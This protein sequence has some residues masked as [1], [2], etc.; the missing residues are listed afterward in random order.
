MVVA[1]GEDPL[2][3]LHRPHRPEGREHLEGVL[4]AVEFDVHDRIGRRTAQRLG[5]PP[6]A[7]DRHQDVGVAVDDHH[8]RCVAVDPIDR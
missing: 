6:G 7:A 8:R 1:P 3:V 2:D 5:E 4:G